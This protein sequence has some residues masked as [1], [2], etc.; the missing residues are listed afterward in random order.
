MHKHVSVLIG[1]YCLLR[2][3]AAV[4]YAMLAGGGELL[5]EILCV[6][7]TGLKQSFYGMNCKCYV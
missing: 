4:M 3:F 7:E 1:I 2:L 5:K 6:S